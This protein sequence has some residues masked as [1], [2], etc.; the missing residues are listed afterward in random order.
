LE[1]NEA[2]MALREL[3][4][5]KHIEALDTQNG[6]LPYIK[7]GTFQ[8][9]DNDIHFN[10]IREDS[11]TYSYINDIQQ[12]NRFVA[13]IA[14]KNKL[15]HS[16]RQAVFDDLI[17][18]EAHLRL[19]HDILVTL[20]INLIDNREQSLLRSANPRTPLET[21]KIVGLLLRSRGN[22]IWKAGNNYSRGFNRGLFYSILARHKLP[23]M[24]KYFS[25][26][27]KA[28]E[29]RGDNILQLGQ[30]ISMRCIRAIEARDA[31]GYRF[32]TSQNND[33]HRAIMYHFDYLT[34]LLA[35]AFDAQALVARHA[36]K[37]NRY[38]ERNTSFR[39]PEFNKALAMNGAE[40]LY[41]IITSDSFRNLM[42]LLFELR[43][44][45]HSD[46]MQ[47][48]IS[49]VAKPEEAFVRVLSKHRDLLW[50]AAERYNSPERWGL[51]QLHGDI[52]LE[53]YTYAVSLVSE[54][55]KYIDAIAYATD[56]TGLFPDGYVVPPLQEKA[57]DDEIYSEN[58]RRR[59]EI[60]G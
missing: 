43:N 28:Q 7:F 49:N 35:G 2:I 40:K 48:F 17:I 9:T 19:R 29:I 25:A 44:T 58:I 60:L 36:Y 23:N 53:P 26:C 20:S 34:L 16:E 51:V 24:W 38:S 15:S 33:T 3:C 56:I 22:Y 54:C 4:N 18:L 50:K 55:F 39:R 57:P 10:I 52:R 12:L 59:I 45:I 8:K 21:A 31:I 14:R 13:G 5:V 27:V 47:N 37:I 46:A 41:N 42:I 1:E 11:I 32:Y 6:L 30:S